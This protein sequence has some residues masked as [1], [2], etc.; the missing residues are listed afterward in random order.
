[1]KFWRLSWRNSLLAKNQSAFTNSTDQNQH[2]GYLTNEIPHAA[3]I[4]ILNKS[5][6]QFVIERIQFSRSHFTAP[7]KGG[8]IECVWFIRIWW[9]RVMKF[10]C[11]NNYTR[12][13]AALNK[14]SIGTWTFLFFVWIWAVMWNGIASKL[15]ESNGTNR[16]AQNENWT[17]YKWLGM[18]AF[19]VTM[20]QIKSKNEVIHRSSCCLNVLCEWMCLWVLCVCVCMSMTTWNKWKE[21]AIERWSNE[22]A[23]LFCMNINVWMW[24]TIQARQI[25]VKIKNTN[26][27]S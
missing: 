17:K 2:Q 6:I 19:S 24:K 21:Y 26:N 18:I 15:K 20:L 8:S 4:A 7:E 22:C 5:E 13:P 23:Y 25:N 10:L 11:S 3:S 9:Q 14:S 1:M 16:N 12:T 27:I